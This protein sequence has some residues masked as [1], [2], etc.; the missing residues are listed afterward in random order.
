MIGIIELIYIPIGA[1]FYLLFTYLVVNHSILDKSL[2][3]AP[4]YLELFSSLPHALEYLIFAG[5]FS[6]GLQL[7][8]EQDLTI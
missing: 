1:C 5:I 8:Q 7:K 4:D 3:Y 2:T 6:F